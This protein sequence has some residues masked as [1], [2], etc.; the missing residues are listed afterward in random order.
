ME[1]T[2]ALTL[3]DVQTHLT[4]TLISSI[5]GASVVA[6]L[7][8]VG[9]YYN[10]KNTLSNQESRIESVSAM[11]TSAEEKI[12]GMQID[13]GMNDVQQ[14]NIDKRLTKVETKVDAIYDLLVKMNK[15]N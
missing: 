2:Q 3:K 10:T 13:L 14:T 9:F 8:V 5:V 15:G 7:S 1:Q 4:K 12:N 6:I 11:A